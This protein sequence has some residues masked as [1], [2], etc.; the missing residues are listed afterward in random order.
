MGK[1]LFYSDNPTIDSTKFCIFM[2]VYAWLKYD[3]LNYN[4]VMKI[5]FLWFEM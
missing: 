4:I 5:Y 3:D 2:V 1:P